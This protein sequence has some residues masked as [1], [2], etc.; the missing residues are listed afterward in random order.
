MDRARQSTVRVDGQLLV[1]IT[2]VDSADRI[3]EVNWADLMSAPRTAAGV[4]IYAWYLITSMLDVAARDTDAGR[5]IG[6][7]LYR[8][9]LLTVTPGAVLFTMSTGIGAV[10]DSPWLRPMILALIT[11]SAALLTWRLRPLG[12][13][14]RW[15]WAWVALVA[16]VTVAAFPA[17]LSESGLLVRLSRPARQ[18]GFTG[19]MLLLSLASLEMWVRW[20]RTSTDT[21]LAHLALMYMPF[22][23]LNSAM[24]WI[25][26]IA[27]SVLARANPERYREWEQRLTPHFDFARV[28]AAATV[29]LGSVAVLALVMPLIGFSLGARQEVI[30]S[31]GA[32]NNRRGAGARTGFRVFLAVTPIL[33]IGLGLYSLWVSMLADRPAKTILETYEMSVWRS[34]PYLAWL[35]G[36]FGVALGV[37]GDVLFYL[38]PN[39]QHPASTRAVCRARLRAAL[40]LARSG[41]AV[42][43]VAHSQGSVV[44]ADLRAAGEL[45][46]PLV[47]CGSPV[48]TLYEPLLGILA[49]A[50]QRPAEWING[51]RDGDYIGGPIPLP[52]VDNRHWG[53]GFHTDY[54]SSADLRK[55]VDEMAARE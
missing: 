3:I 27:L 44:A 21:R 22:I 18:I 52:G 48:S 6:V 16:I 24:T 36:P 53:Q 1:E 47:T 30:G 42:V 33:L 37:I 38:Q 54:W 2:D 51:Y 35:V 13:H 46:A 28:E 9:A 20:R 17:P 15:L 7:R 39:D 25:G 5:L 23:V 32:M 8:W 12:E 40:R 26:V 34:L 55:A 11:L 41:G 14:F 19:V 45:R 50:P 31:S 49:Q 29:V 10:V 4:L 43:V